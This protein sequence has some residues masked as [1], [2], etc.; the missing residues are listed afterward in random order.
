MEI[1][2]WVKRNDENNCIDAIQD[3]A[4]F[5]V[6]HASCLICALEKC[7]EVVVDERSMHERKKTGNRHGAWNQD[8]AQ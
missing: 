1:T 7:Y 2:L 4:G 3:G 6:S 8:H 5:A